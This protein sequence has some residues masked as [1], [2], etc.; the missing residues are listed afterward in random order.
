MTDKSKFCPIYDTETE[1]TTDEMQAYLLVNELL[2]QIQALKKEIVDLRVEVNSYIP[3][4]MLTP[5]PFPVGDLPGSCA[6]CDMPA[7]KRY[8]QFFGEYIPE[9]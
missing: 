1:E 3:A 6:Y 8:E 2:S 9:Y 7:M 5:Y 4:G